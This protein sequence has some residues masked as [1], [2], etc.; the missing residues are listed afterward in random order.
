MTLRIKEPAVTDIKKCN[1]ISDVGQAANFEKRCHEFENRLAYV[2]FE[3]SPVAER[4]AFE[5][6]AERNDFKVKTWFGWE[7]FARS[8][9]VLVSDEA[10]ERC[11][12]ALEEE[13]LKENVINV[14]KMVGRIAA[15]SAL[16]LLGF[17]VALGTFRAGVAAGLCAPGFAENNVER[18]YFQ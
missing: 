18:D 10:R 3:S 5:L 14:A 15:I 16:V 7:P 12:K 17:D 9:S 2:P 11:G 13:P 4:C 6:C 8:C 1:Q